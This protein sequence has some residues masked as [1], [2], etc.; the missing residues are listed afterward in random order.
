MIDATPE[1]TEYK[2]DK[3]LAVCKKADKPTAIGKFE[4]WELC[5]KCKEISNG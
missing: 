4:Y 3:C 5:D 2:C 1:K